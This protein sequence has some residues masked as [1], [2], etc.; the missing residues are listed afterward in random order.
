MLQAMCKWERKKIS[1]KL[2]EEPGSDKS[3]TG[4]NITNIQ[5]GPAQRVVQLSKGSEG[6][7]IPFHH[8]ASLSWWAVVFAVEVPSSR[9]KGGRRWQASTHLLEPVPSIVSANNSLLLICES[10]QAPFMPLP[11]CFPSPSYLLCYLQLS[12]A[13]DYFSVSPARR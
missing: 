5:P 8:A 2:P 3:V 9:G 11:Y 13:S 12:E 7:D 4:E 6:L 10:P 1:F